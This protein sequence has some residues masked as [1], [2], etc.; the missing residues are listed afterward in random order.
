MNHKTFL[1]V[2]AGSEI[3][4]MSQSEKRVLRKTIDAND[5]NIAADEIAQAKDSRNLIAAAKTLSKYG[6]IITDPL[7]LGFDDE[8]SSIELTDKG[9]TA[10]DRYGI[11]NDDTLITQD[12]QESSSPEE[13][14]P[15]TNPNTGAPIEQ[16][17]TAGQNNPNLKGNGVGLELSSFFQSVNDLVN[18]KD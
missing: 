12:E 1:E 11:Q 16:P 6:Y 3:M 10:I 13:P 17:S 14:P 4:R 8:P 2:M 9:Q 5:P 18:L 7:V 15:A